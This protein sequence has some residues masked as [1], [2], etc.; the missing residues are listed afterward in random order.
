MGIPICNKP[1]AEPQAEALHPDREAALQ[2]VV[3]Y[4]L[5]RAVCPDGHVT[6]MLRTA[7]ANAVRGRLEVEVRVT[8]MTLK[9]DTGAVVEIE[10]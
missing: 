2:T 5:F 4:V 6:Q 3:D 9:G 1:W 7:I 8:R 10:R